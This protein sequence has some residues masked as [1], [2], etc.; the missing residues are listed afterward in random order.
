MKY[1]H[2]ETGEVFEDIY[3]SVIRFCRERDCDERCPIDA[4]SAGHNCRSWA[5]EHP[6]EAALIMGL[7]VVEDNAT[8]K[9]AVVKS[10]FCEQIGV[11]PGQPFIVH[12]YPYRNYPPMV[13]G[14]DGCV[15]LYSPDGQKRHKVGGR[16]I[17]W[18]V[19]HPESVE[20]CKGYAPQEV[21]FKKEEPMEQKDK[22]H[23]CQDLGVEVGERFNVVGCTGFDSCEYDENQR[24]FIDST[25]TL[26]E[27]MKPGCDS[28]ASIVDG[29]VVCLVWND[30]DRIIRKHR[31]TQE[32]VSQAKDIRYVF[33]REDTI[34]RT[35]D[36]ALC[37]GHIILNSSLLPSLH[38]G[39]SVRL[40]EIVKP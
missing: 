8:G 13:Y 27:E 15:R 5:V 11:L 26:L 40:E 4:P 30:P 16:A 1:R 37:Y 12:S 10:L 14:D 24:F 21:A 6:A 2:P 19:D 35:D 28:P 25:G 23:I 20:P 34:K 38:P 39:Q 33:G 7:E 9:E 29:R 3:Q 32:E 22:P 18:I 31:F 36:G 17:T